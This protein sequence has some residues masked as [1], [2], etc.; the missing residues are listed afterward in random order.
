MANRWGAK[1]GH[2][3]LGHPMLVLGCAK[4]FF[5]KNLNELFGQPNVSCWDSTL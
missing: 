4:K 1:M 3:L 5:W 2:P